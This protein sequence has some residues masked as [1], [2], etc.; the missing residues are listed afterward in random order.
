[1]SEFIND[2]CKGCGGVLKHDQTTGKYICN[3]CGREF[4]RNQ[5]N[6]LQQ[7][8]KQD[9]E[10][11]RTKIVDDVKAVFSETIEKS[12]TIYGENQDKLIE[13]IEERKQ[14]T[15]KKKR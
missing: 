14:K 10:E 9:L 6:T 4:I 11:Q 3:Y 5:D 8:T 7:I 13:V 1:M 12:K 15:E 2:I